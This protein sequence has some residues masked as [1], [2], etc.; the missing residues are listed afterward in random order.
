MFSLLVMTYL[1]T[2]RVSL[3]WMSPSNALWIMLPHMFVYWWLHVGTTSSE[4]QYVDELILLQISSITVVA[5]AVSTLPIIAYDRYA[6]GLALLSG[7]SYVFD[8]F[9]LTRMQVMY[10]LRNVTFH[11]TANA[12][13]DVLS[14]RWQFVVIFPSFSTWDDIIRCYVDS[15]LIC[16]LYLFDIEES[17][18]YIC[19]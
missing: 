19:L 4:V 16:P 14:K 5:S 3:D 6:H 7:K 8:F 1:I 11:N 9:T 13:N 17:S 10:F 12:S 15:Y 2:F 18:S